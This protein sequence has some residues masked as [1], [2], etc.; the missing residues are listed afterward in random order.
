MD[1]TFSASSTKRRFDGCHLF[2]VLADPVVA[3]VVGVVDA[4]GHGTGAVLV[5]NVGQPVAVVSRVQHRAG[6]V[7]AALAFRLF[8]YQCEVLKFQCRLEI[9][10][11]LLLLFQR[12]H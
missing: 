1:V 10:K 5:H 4:L 12:D 2:G 8:S 11:Y 6:A 9:C 7:L 3:A